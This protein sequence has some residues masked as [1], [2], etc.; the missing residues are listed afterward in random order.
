M[1]KG[2]C[3]ID[4]CTN[5]AACRKMCSTHYGRWRRDGGAG[6]GLCVADGCVSP[7]S[8]REWCDKHYQRLRKY[9]DANYEVDARRATTITD[10]P[11]GDR[12]CTD[13]KEAKPLSEYHKDKRGLKGRRGICKPCRGGYMFGYYQENREQKLRYEVERRANNVE[14]IRNL[15]KLRYQRDKDKRIEL[16][17]G[18]SQNRRARI[19]GRELDKGITVIRLRKLYGDACPYCS[20]RMD[21]KAGTQ[22]EYNKK[23]ASIEHIIPISKGGTHTWDN[24]IL[25]CLGCNLA[26]GNRAAPTHIQQPLGLDLMSEQ[27][28]AA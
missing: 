23:R 6:R 12:V 22:G 28:G 3:S 5:T 1:S 16:A 11:N 19:L 4:G 24:V 21:F 25:A 26:R 8:A 10:L 7:A 14:H 9:G 17:T 13:C 20:C 27:E 18:H 15:D 2:T